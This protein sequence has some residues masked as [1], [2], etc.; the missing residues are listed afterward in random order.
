MERIERT[1]HICVCIFRLQSQ[2]NV[3]NPDLNNISRWWWW[4]W[5]SSTTKHGKKLPIMVIDCTTHCTIG[6]IIAISLLSSHSSQP[7]ERERKNLDKRAFSTS[8]TH[9]TILSAETSR[10]SQLK[11]KQ[12]LREFKSRI[13]LTIVDAYEHKMW[14]KYAIIA[15]SFNMRYWLVWLA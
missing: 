4:W 9:D 11:N 3:A 12:F 1:H 6:S 8:T 14:R 13:T 15:V 10:N 2:L 7:S 5:C